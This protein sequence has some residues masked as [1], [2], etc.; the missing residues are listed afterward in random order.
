MQEAHYER[1][2]GRVSIAMMRSDDYCQYP[3]AC[4]TLWVRPAILLEQIHFFYDAAGAYCGYMTWARVAQDVE[5]RL[6]NDPEVLLH[7]SEWNEGERLWILDFCIFR[8]NVRGFIAESRKL[9]G[10]EEIARSVRRNNDGTVRKVVEWS[11]KSVPRQR[12]EIQLE[13]A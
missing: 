1:D 12:P 5:S 9:F 8:G 4:L 7:V 11:R 2:M 3:I 6:I 13:V 10:D